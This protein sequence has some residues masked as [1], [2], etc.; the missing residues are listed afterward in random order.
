MMKKLI[1][2]ELIEKYMEE[3]KLSKNEFY[4]IVVSINAMVQDLLIYEK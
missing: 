1:K 4:K 2:T 3:R